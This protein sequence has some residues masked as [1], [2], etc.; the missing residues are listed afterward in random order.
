MPRSGDT[1]QKPAPVMPIIASPPSDD[2]AS[3]RSLSALGR[4]RAAICAGPSNVWPTSALNRSRGGGARRG[5]LGANT[6]GGVLPRGAVGD[7]VPPVGCPLLV[8]KR[9]PAWDEADEGSFSKSRRGG[10]EECGHRHPGRSWW[11]RTRP[12]IA[13]RF[14][15]PHSG[16]RGRRRLA[17]WGEGQVPHADVGRARVMR[18]ARS[19]ARR[20]HARRDRP[21]LGAGAR[22]SDVE[23]DVRGGRRSPGRISRTQDARARQGKRRARRRPHHQVGDES[24]RRDL[25][26]D[27]PDCDSRKD[28]PSCRAASGQQHHVPGP[29]SEDPVREPR[30]RG[31]DSGV[32]SKDVK[33]NEVVKPPR[34]GRPMRGAQH[35]ISDIPVGE[36]SSLRYLDAN[37]A[38]SRGVEAAAVRLG[39]GHSARKLRVSGPGKVPEQQMTPWPANAPHRQQA[40]PSTVQASQLI[41]VG[42]E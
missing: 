42:G 30:V 20:A 7:G 6:R 19:G 15:G 26:A 14:S 16:L 40:Q 37:G 3:S 5:Q 29:D 24:E 35:P 13:P 34:K 8:R 12:S 9:G 28:V 33:G 10:L 39:H 2:T 22:G 25:S 41:V 11:G 32:A 38:G 27:P 18:K 17:W 23:T 36:G 1:A 31:S 21:V 4:G